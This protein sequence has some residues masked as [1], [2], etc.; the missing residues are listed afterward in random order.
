[1]SDAFK[2]LFILVRR[3]AVWVMYTKIPEQ[4]FQ[5]S[6]STGNGI[7]AKAASEAVMGSGA[8]FSADSAFD[9]DKVF[10]AFEHVDQY[11]DRSG[12]QG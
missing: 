7:Y 10:A 8:A 9:S 3:Q 11:A 1:M 6:R 2:E 12:Q 4:P 5:M